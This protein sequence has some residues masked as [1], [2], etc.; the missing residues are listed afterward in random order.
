MPKKYS[1]LHELIEQDK[2]ANRYFQTLPGYVKDT[3]QARLQNINS[4][5]SLC[6]YAENLLRSDE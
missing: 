5:A 3:M 2:E 6:D 1:G 4:F